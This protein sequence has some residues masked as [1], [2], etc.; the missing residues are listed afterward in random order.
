MAKRGDHEGS[1]FKRSNGRWG[2][3]IQVNGVRR[4]VY[5]RT[6]KEVQERLLAVQQE[7]K[8]GVVAPQ[9][10]PKTI[11]EFLRFWLDD[12]AKHNVRF[13][14]WE[15][16]DLCVRRVLPH[17]GKLKLSALGHAELQ[18]LWARLKEK[19]LSSRSVA[20]CRSVLHNAFRLAVEWKYVSHNP[21]DYAPAPRVKRR[22]MKTLSAGQV[23]TLI[24]TTKGTRWHALWVMLV[25]T[26]LRL[27]EVTGLRWDDVDLERGRA[28]IQRGVRRQKGQGLLFVEAKSESSTRTVHLTPAA[29][30]ALKEHRQLLATLRSSAGESW[31]ERDLLFPSLT[32]GLVDP[33]RVNNAFHIALHKAG[34]PRVCPHDLRHTT[35]TLLL[36]QGVNPKVVQDL[37]GHS[38][39]NITLDIYSHVTPR[40]QEDAT[41]A[42]Q[43][44]LF[45]EKG[46]TKQ[47]D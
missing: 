12:V 23:R 15:H 22:E 16:Y 31:E 14:T 39:I 20:H 45:D 34:L 36:E 33:S 43:Q 13:G 6:R 46:N 26:G 42:M 47:G 27:G 41:Q 11:E 1:I 8:A 18:S 44:L 21:V 28:V 3:A 37:L 24:T 4:Y 25:T 32:G 9:Q 19:G 10:A 40:M 2:A 30:A 29:I 38:T 17:I 35:A 5:A 7:A